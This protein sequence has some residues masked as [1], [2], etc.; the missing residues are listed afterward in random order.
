MLN[1]PADRA[2]VYLSEFG[3]QFPDSAKFYSYGVAWY[4]KFYDDVG[5]SLN[6]SLEDFPKFVE[7]NGLPSEILSATSYK[8]FDKYRIKNTRFPEENWRIDYTIDPKPTHIE[9]D[10]S[11]QLL[12]AP[13][14]DIRS[15]AF[16]DDIKQHANDNNTVVVED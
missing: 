6:V 14:R 11:L 7:N 12:S 16:L 13:T 15:E 3:F 1:P 8:Y 4:G 10:I 5:F 9:V 2:S